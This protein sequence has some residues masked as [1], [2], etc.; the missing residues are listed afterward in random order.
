MPYKRRYNLDHPACPVEPLWGIFCEA[1][2][3]D[4][5]FSNPRKNVRKPLEIW[6]AYRQY[7]V[8]ASPLSTRF[9]SKTAIALSKDNVVATAKPVPL[10]TEQYDPW[11]LL[12]TSHGSNVFC[13]FYNYCKLAVNSIKTLWIWMRPITKHLY[14]FRTCTGMIGHAA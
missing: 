4:D 3:P 10:P 7:R 14:F 1:A 5:A 8:V 12:E 13:F 6:T 2:S 11:L 9:T